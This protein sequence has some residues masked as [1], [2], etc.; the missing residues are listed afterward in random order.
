MSQVNLSAG[1]IA[2]EHCPK[3]ECNS[4]GLQ[5]LPC[6]IVSNKDFVICLRTGLDFL[7]SYIGGPPVVKYGVDPKDVHSVMQMNMTLRSNFV[8]K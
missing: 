1:V 6:G 3:N 7:V 8:C 2:F 4:T 5:M